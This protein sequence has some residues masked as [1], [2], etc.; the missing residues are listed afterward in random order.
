MRSL[1]KRQVVDARLVHHLHMCRKIGEQRIEPIIWIAVFVEPKGIVAF[2]AL[3]QLRRC[4]VVLKINNHCQ[5]LRMEKARELST[6][7][8]LAGRLRHAML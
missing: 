2:A 6:L 3:H 1:I 7:R 5:L 8:G 4:I